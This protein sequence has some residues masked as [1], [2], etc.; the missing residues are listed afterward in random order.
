MRLSSLSWIL[1][2]QTVNI[3]RAIALVSYCSNHKCDETE[4]D[5]VVVFLLLA[6]CT[7]TK[8]ILVNSIVNAISHSSLKRNTSSLRMRTS[9]PNIIHPS[10]VVRH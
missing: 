10:H 5:G 1:V 4:M 6:K 9:F 2:E 8:G 3:N 7:G